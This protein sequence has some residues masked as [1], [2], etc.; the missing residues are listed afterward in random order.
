VRGTLFAL[1]AGLGLAVGCP[2]MAQATNKPNIL[3]IWGDDV[4]YWNIS[5]YNQGMMG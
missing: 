5:A 4:G 1:L 2:A 3:V